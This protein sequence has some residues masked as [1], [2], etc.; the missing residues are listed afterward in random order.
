MEANFHYKYD[1]CL[2]SHHYQTPCLTRLVQSL[3]RTLA[4]LCPSLLQCGLL[5]QHPLEMFVPS[6]FS[7][8][9]NISLVKLLICQVTVKHTINKKNILHIDT[10]YK[11]YLT[12]SLK[13]Y[14]LPDSVKAFAMKLEC[15]L[16]EHLIF[17]RPLIRE[18]C[19]VCQIHGCPI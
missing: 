16:K 11:I 6:S 17:D 18:W 2:P 7:M 12:I 9:N 1:L 13:I 19:E 3:H 14:H 8:S 10:D 15:L 5:Q 4:C